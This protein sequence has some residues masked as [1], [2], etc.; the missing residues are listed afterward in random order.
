MSNDVRG[1]EQPF[2]P[3]LTQ[4]NLIQAEMHLLALLLAGAA[5]ALELLENVQVP[6]PGHRQRAHL[7][8]CSL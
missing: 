5:A 7:C 6:V 2:I 1:M 3:L 8:R 4:S